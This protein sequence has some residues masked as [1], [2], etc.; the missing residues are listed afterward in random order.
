MGTENER[1]YV[2][3]PRLDIL[4]NIVNMVDKI[5]SIEQAYLLEAD[6]QVLRIRKSISSTSMNPFYEL[7]YKHKLHNRL[8]EINTEIDTNDFYDLMATTDNVLRKTRYE[9]KVDALIWQVDF[10]YDVR[11]S[12]PHFIMA[13]VELPLNVTSPSRIPKFI[14]DYLL[15]EVPKDNTDFSNNQ[16][17]D[18]EYTVSLYEKLMNGTYEN[19]EE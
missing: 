5:I 19:G 15:Y 7:T 1:K 4:N 16:L 10:F 3:E 8:L 18:I 13:E 2:L 12:D 11:K 6:N 17:I 14:M 9:I